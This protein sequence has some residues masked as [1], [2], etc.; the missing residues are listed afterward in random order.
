MDIQTIIGIV[1]LIIIY[2]MI[3]SERVH[4]TIAAM[5][6]AALTIVVLAAMGKPV[7]SVLEYIDMNTIILLVSMMIIVTIAEK[8]GLFNVLSWRI[9]KLSKGSLFALLALLAVLTGV[10]SAF[11]DNVTTV[12]IVGPITLEIVRRAH[13]DPRPFVLSEIFASN[14]GGTAT[15]I[16]DPPNIII[17]SQLKLGFNTFLVNTAPISF[18]IL[19]I[20]PLIMFTL[21]RKDIKDKK[22]SKRITEGIP[23][24]PEDIVLYKESIAVLILVIVLFMTEPIHHIPSPMVALIGASILLLVSRVSITDVITSVDWTTIVFFMMLFIVVGGVSELG[25]IN[26]IAKSLADISA[27]PYIL[28]VVILWISMLLSGF[29]DNIPYVATM[30]PVIKSLNVALGLHNAMLVWALSLGGCFGGNL[31]PVGAS[32]NVVLLSIA[33]RHGCHITWK[34]YLKYGTVVI[35]LSGVLSSLYLLRYA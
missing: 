10:L 22:I 1:I 6:G 23:H 35:I 4:R 14:I 8:S 24:K 31:T 13:V 3:A 5:F 32:A 28:A 29:I 19:L 21:Y 27:S 2:S 16:G 18:L 26:F 33:D 15:L 34:E 12:L 9:A 20:V 17:G 30:I 11:V 7:E 25:V